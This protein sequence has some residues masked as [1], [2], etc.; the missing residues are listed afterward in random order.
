V[1][2]IE[3]RVTML[4]QVLAQDKTAEAALSNRSGGP[5]PRTPLEHATL[6]VAHTKHHP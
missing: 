3:H 1:D 2:L 4:R 5:E 6:A